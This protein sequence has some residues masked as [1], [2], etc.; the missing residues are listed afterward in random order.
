ME[1]AVESKEKTKK[2]HCRFVRLLLFF[3]NSILLK[4]LF[5]SIHPH[6]LLSVH[7]SNSENQIHLWDSQSYHPTSM[8]HLT[9]ALTEP[10]K[11]CGLPSQKTG[12]HYK[13]A[14]MKPEPSVPEITSLTF[15]YTVSKNP[16]PF[17]TLSHVACSIH[18]D[19]YSIYLKI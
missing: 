12:G 8:P 14:P 18:S 2:T 4:W 6:Y 7:V 9:N 5:I 17:S 19:N 10:L 15:V 13:E 3:L 1:V 16:E 11:S